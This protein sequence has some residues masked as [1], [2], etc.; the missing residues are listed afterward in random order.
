MFQRIFNNPEK[1]RS[2]LACNVSDPDFLQY[3]KQPL[4]G[5]NAPL[6]ETEFLSLDF[7]TTGLNPQQEAILTIGYTV[8]KNG[9]VLLK[10]NGHH[11]I[12]INKP[13]PHESVI[14]HHIT[15]DRIKEGEPLREALATLLRKLSGR[16]ALVHYQGI[17]KQFL[18]A[19]CQQHYGHDLPAIYV[20]TLEIARRR[21]SRL[22]VRYGPHHLRLFNLRDY[23]KLPRYRAH[24][25]L[26]DAIAT[27]ELFLAEMSS[28]GTT[29]DK[30]R[31]KEVI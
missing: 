24:S 11:L 16:V 31:L 22:P 14:I 6:N 1:T 3:L 19:A 18:N 27:A 15:D 9:R 30:I 21:L 7:E 29:L 26:E 8:I 20:D 2:K 13:I 17:E 23:H 10:E 28:K 25:A 12:Q 4:P 5:L